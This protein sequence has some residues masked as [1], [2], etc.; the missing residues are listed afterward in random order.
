MEEREGDYLGFCGSFA[1]TGVDT[2]VTGGVR[3]I[4]VSGVKSSVAEPESVS[5]C[6]NEDGLGEANSGE[7][8][9]GLVGWLA[10]SEKFSSPAL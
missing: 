10:V 1:D 8:E 2:R 9:L 3:D 5:G 6:Q 4:S 7:S